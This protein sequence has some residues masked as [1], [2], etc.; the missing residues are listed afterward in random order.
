MIKIRRN[1]RA[2]D[3]ALLVEIRRVQAEDAEAQTAEKSP[4]VP[5]AKANS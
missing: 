5:V 1:V 3:E 2:I 4:V